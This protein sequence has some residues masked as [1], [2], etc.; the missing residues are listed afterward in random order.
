[1]GCGAS[2]AALLLPHPAVDTEFGPIEGKRILLRDRRVVNVFLGVP[3]AEPPIGNRRFKRPESPEPWTKTLPCKVY[4]KRPM[5]TNYIWDITHTGRGVSEDC[6][7]LNIMAPAWSN[8]EFKNGFPVC[9]YVHGGGY[10]MDSAAGYR[11]GNI[12]RTLVSKE[13]LV[14]TPEYR[15]GYFGFF[16]L[17]DK[18]CKGNF[19][20]W[21]Q[22]M[23]LKFV[24]DNIAKFGGDP[25]KITVMG[26]SAG[27]TSTD[28]L[29]LSPITRDLFHQKICMAGSAENQWS[30]S[31]K[32][33]VIKRCREK[34]LK[35]GFVRTSES[36][37]WTEEENKQ[38]M[39]Y[40]RK[41]PSA[42]LVYPVH[43][44]FNIF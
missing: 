19:A 6:L 22:A 20:L 43:S 26:Q 11:Y 24:K 29:S 37:E 5:Q 17:D 25:E 35:L 38:C 8:K 13:V 12:A 28:L 3:F 16:C 42:K 32:E 39:E 10:V 40:L 34:A 7:Y 2:K 4:K 27:G 14:V 9:V 41:L 30:M 44:K 18:H 31:E 15:L 36:P 21:D 1:M 23:A 33:W